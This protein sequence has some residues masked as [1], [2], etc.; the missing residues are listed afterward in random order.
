M[1]PC[2]YIATRDTF[3]T[4]IPFK[5]IQVMSF[6]TVVNTNISFPDNYKIYIQLFKIN[7]TCTKTL[8]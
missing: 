7:L 3:F 2:I 6:L 4:V 8:I 5:T 1:T